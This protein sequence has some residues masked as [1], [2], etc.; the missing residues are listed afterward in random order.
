MRMPRRMVCLVLAVGAPTLMGCALDL[1]A[2]QGGDAGGMDAGRNDAGRIDGG[3][4]DGGRRDA[5][6][7]DGGLLD[8]GHDAGPET[9]DEVCP[10]GLCV[11]G[12]CVECVTDLHCEDDTLFCDEAGRCVQCTD[13]AHCGGE[14]CTGGVCVECRNDAAC[15]SGVCTSEGACLLGPCET[16]ESN[17]Q[18]EGD[19]VC[20]IGAGLLRRCLPLDFSGCPPGFPESGPRADPAGESRTV[21]LPGGETT[22][23]AYLNTVIR[24]P[25]E[26]DADCGSRGVCGADGT[27]T[28]DC[29]DNSYCP[30]DFDC[31]GTPGVCERALYGRAP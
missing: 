3:P 23:V 1:G 8:A 24:T 14:V 13:D 26:G 7:L 10:V 5:G 22:C 29:E 12:A 2:L 31:S 30:V 18:C 20:V 28:Y 21:C 9:C 25:C 19:A 15:E 17:A 27:C 6:D 16:C 4:T 11:D